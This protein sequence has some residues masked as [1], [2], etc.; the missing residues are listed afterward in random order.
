LSCGI[1]GPLSEDHR[2][3]WDLV[4]RVF[5]GTLEAIYLDQ[6]KILDIA[7]DEVLEILIYA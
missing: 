5:F 6:V 7:A 4:W 3:Q 2:E 1:F